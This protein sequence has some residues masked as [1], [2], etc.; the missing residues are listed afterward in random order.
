VKVATRSESGNFTT[1]TLEGILLQ[2]NVD[3]FAVATGAGTNLLT[4][5]WATPGASAYL[6]GF[7]F[8]YDPAETDEFLGFQPEHYCDEIAALFLAMEAFVRARRHYYLRGN[9]LK[10]ETV[11]RKA[12]GLALTASV[13]S[14]IA[15]RGEH[16]AFL[17][18]ISNLTPPV[19]TARKIVL[20]KGVGQVQR[21]ADDL[22][23]S[24]KVME[25]LTGIIFDET[26]S[27]SSFTESEV[28][29]MLFLPPYPFAGC[30]KDSRKNV[31]IPG[32]YN[33]LHASHLRMGETLH[34]RC[35]LT[36]IYTICIDPPHK[37][38]LSLLDILDRR[39]MFKALAP[40]KDLMFTREDPLF[41]DKMVAFPNSAWAVGGDTLDRLLDPKWGP[42]TEQVCDIIDE[43]GSK[44]FFF[45]AKEGDDWIDT[46]SII[47]KYKSEKLASLFDKKIFRIGEELPD[48]RSTDIRTAASR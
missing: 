48:V 30:V 27:V 5:L 11:D 31:Y 10:P 41:I 33:P 2:G 39:A 9:Y 36:P 47:T 34:E 26:Y 20:Q 14:K 40:A 13:A 23:A 19:H 17:A 29:E 21:Q 4:Q 3:L 1:S 7:Q 15:H 28:R 24:E 38:P 12:I 37:P 45:P 32:N 42:T 6:K 44:I 8:P 35:G 25:E 22:A 46:P 18:T 43:T 16:R